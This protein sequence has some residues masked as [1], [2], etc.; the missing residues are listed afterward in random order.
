M[1]DIIPPGNSVKWYKLEAMDMYRDIPSP[2]GLISRAVW[3]K[4]QHLCLS[5]RDV[6][7]W[8]EEL[9]WLA[10]HW[11]S[12]SFEHKLKRLGFATTVYE[13]WSA[14]NRKIFQQ[15]HA[16][17]VYI[18]QKVVEDIQCARASWERIPKT[19][20]NREL[21]LEW[22]LSHKIFVQICI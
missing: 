22:G 4:V 3:K 11:C 6:Y 12:N 2:F 10:D 9:N 13:L 7:S 17:A 8:N 19:R 5:F 15:R 18:V 1:K 20:E 21:A 14:R 16:T